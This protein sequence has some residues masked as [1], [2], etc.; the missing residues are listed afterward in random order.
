[1]NQALSFRSG[2]RAANR[3]L[4]SACTEGLAD[5]MSRVTER[6]LTLYRLWA[7]A[8]AGILVSGNIQVDSG[9]GGVICVPSWVCIFP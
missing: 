7:T 4:K 6:H 5:P 3:L 9:P 1:M 8:G 2:L